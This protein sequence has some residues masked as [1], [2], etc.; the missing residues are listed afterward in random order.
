MLAHS[1]SR[2]LSA[3]SRSRASQITR[4]FARHSSWSRSQRQMSMA[5][6]STASADGQNTPKLNIR[7][8]TL[9]G[10]LMIVGIGSTAYG[11]YEFYSA[12]TMWPKAVREDLRA[13]VKA[14]NQGNLNTSERYLT[15]ALET[16]LALPLTDLSPNPHAKLSG[17]S[18][19]LG[20]VLE[21]NHKPDEAYAVY[22]A[23]LERLQRAIGEGSSKGAEGGVTVSGP[24]RVRAAALAFKLAEM[25][26]E[27]SQPEAEEE[28]W[29]VYAVEELLRVLRDT[30]T[31]AG[32][33]KAD[34][35]RDVAEDVKGGGYSDKVDLDELE[36]PAWV[37][38]DDV[39]APLE[40]LG[41]FYGRT[42]KQEY[43]IPLYLSALSILLPPNSHHASAETKC[44]GAHIM[45]SLASS[46]A[47][48]ST[49]PERLPKAEAWAKKA[50]AVVTSVRSSSVQEDPEVL[51]Q[52]D[53]VLVAAL[54]NMGSL[55]ESGGS[56]DEAKEWYTSAQK[57]ATS[58]KMRE[59]IIESEQAL[60]RLKRH[61]SNE[62]RS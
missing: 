28:K 7:V 38:R 14:K 31:H 19:V 5:S 37:R 8:S 47:Q 55:K 6:T 22:V 1:V 18:I 10:A 42:G 62:T 9:F 56:I 30:Q 11:L 57:Q 48:A 16:A 12:F 27:Y 17:I 58:I 52:C 53:A 41:A 21:T 13:G 32:K 61:T 3:S 59:G 45:N 40:R 50:I 20:E 46:L 24:E 60:R 49:T 4:A 33:Q 29:L 23:A 36:L 44:Q 25:A 34:S 54:F 15:R 43:S 2:Q 26:E 35:S 51:G 39:V